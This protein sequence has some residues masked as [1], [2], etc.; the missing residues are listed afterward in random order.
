MIAVAYFLLAVLTAADLRFSGVSDLARQEGERLV[1]DVP[2]GQDGKT[3]GA[4][5]PIA[6]FNG[7]GFRAR[8]RCRGTD[9]SRPAKD[10]NGLKFMFR[11]VD[12]DGKVHYPNTPSRLGTWDW[13]E[14]SCHDSFAAADV[15]DFR[16][17]MGLQESSGKLEF[18]LSSLVIEPFELFPKVN[19]DFRVKY[20][21]RTI[22]DVRR[23]G[24]MLP[25]KPCTADDFKTLSAWGVNLVRYQMTWFESF[26]KARGKTERDLPCYRAW[27][28][29]KLDHLES[30]VLP[31]AR[32]RGI[33]V[34]VD[35]HNAPGGKT[36]AGE[37]AVFEEDV[38][39]E[40]FLSTWRTIAT[41]FKGN[42]DVIYGYDLI[43]EPAQV[44]EVKCDYWNL[45][46]RAAE[47]VRSID[48]ETAIII[49][50]N[51]QDC[52][53]TYAYL[54]PL[55]MHNVIYQLHIYQ[56]T[57]FTHQ[58]VWAG[59]P[60]NAYPQPGKVDI[61]WLR[62]EMKPVIEFSRRHHAKIYVGEFSAIAWAEG[63][64]RY[65]RDV[66]TICE[67]NGWDWTYHAFREYEGWSV[68][69]EWKHPIKEKPVPSTDNPRLRVL[70]AG[71]KGEALPVQPEITD[72]FPCSSV[73]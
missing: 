67:E 55:K 43:N 49:E 72:N 44:G 47:A 71:F 12:A 58:G 7:K 52:S 1:I 45:Q 5:I 63:A 50:S 56:P 32:K 59:M 64:D 2:A 23:R 6:G 28:K 27:L 31:E 42:E 10:W 39:I 62:R 17:V 57:S 54:S 36:S 46:R 37:Q 65:L 20:P 19:W 21:R 34:V 48:P 66:M 8:I 26:A 73:F 68:E 24:V 13:T 38:F 11:W 25:A 18:D 22:C 35:L 41:R 29:E 30:F 15:R 51:G 3:V 40:E 14:I 4:A 70:K 33:K 16:L 9:V 69:H 53:G 61:D 60:P